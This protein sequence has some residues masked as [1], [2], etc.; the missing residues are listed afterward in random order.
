[1]L[2]FLMYNQWSIPVASRLSYPRQLEVSIAH[3]MVP[4]CFYQN[5]MGCYG[6]C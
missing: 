1:M 4:V 5:F 3:D 6:N 2:S